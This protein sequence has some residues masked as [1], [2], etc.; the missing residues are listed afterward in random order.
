MK[1]NLMF[2]L[3]SISTGILSLCGIFLY[4]Y[5][6]PQKYVID[7]S[8]EYVNITVSENKSAFPISKST[9]FVVEYEYPEENRILKEHIESIPALLGC[10]KAGVEKYLETYMDNLSRDEKEAGLVSYK[11]IS[12]RENEITL[13]KTY[14]KPEPSGYYAKSYNGLIVILNGDEKT[15]YEYTRIS[16]ASL[17]EDM[18]PEIIN[19]YY[20]A[21]DEEL[22]SFLENYTS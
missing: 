10:D 1:R 16:L 3:F 2:A 17:P 13:R 12:Y 8:G 5:F 19:G 4:N 11:L 22:Y 21:D 6:Y 9:S 14:K 15:V 20:L 7:D 18:R